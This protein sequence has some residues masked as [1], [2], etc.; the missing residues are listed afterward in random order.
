MGDVGRTLMLLGGVMFIV[1]ALISLSGR[2]P[3][4]GNLPGDVVVKRDN[5]T[6]I[7]PLGSMLVISLLLTLVLNLIL[8]FF[9]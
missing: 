5:F 1:G 3:W 6:L 9:R 8:R 2:V 4:L 7:A